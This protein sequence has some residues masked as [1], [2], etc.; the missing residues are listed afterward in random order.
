MNPEVKHPNIVT[1]S[2]PVESARTG[3]MIRLLITDHRFEV[4]DNQSQHDAYIRDARRILDAESKRLNFHGLDRLLGALII[5]F[6]GNAYW[7]KEN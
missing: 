1:I 5:E 2:E 4:L 3:E 6:L 7:G